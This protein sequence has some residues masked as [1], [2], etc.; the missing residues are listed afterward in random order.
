[1]SALAAIPVSGYYE[2]RWWRPSLQRSEVLLRERIDDEI[3]AQWHALRRHRSID[4]DLDVRSPW[5][6]ASGFFLRPLTRRCS[7]CHRY[8]RELERLF[9][10][11]HVGVE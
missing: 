10:L 8:V 5:H 11:R 6:H 9:A 3:A 2:R 4:G 1:M 7:E